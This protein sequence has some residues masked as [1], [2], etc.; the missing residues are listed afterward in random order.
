MISDAVPATDDPTPPRGVLLDYPPEA[1]VQIRVK[2]SAS[3]RALVALPRLLLLLGSI[4]LLAV[5]YQHHIFV[6][7]W[8]FGLPF[9]RWLRGQG[10]SSLLVREQELALSTGRWFGGPLLLPRALVKSIEIGQAGITLG[11]QRALV[12]RLTDQRELRLFVGL[13]AEQASFV[14]G[15]LQRWLVADF[16]A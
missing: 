15:G 12:L 14:H 6:V 9:V 16:W 4:A 5:A 11:Y 2:I 13:S 7:F 3:A 8:F 1:V 10:R